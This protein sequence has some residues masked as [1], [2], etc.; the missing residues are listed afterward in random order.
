MPMHCAGVWRRGRRE[1]CRPACWQ[2]CLLETAGEE[3]FRHLTRAEEKAL[4]QPILRLR[5]A[6]CHPQALISYFC[7]FLYS[8]V[9]VLYL[10]WLPAVLTI[11]SRSP[12]SAV[13]QVGSGG[14]KSL[15]TAKAPMTM[16]A[17][18]GG[19]HQ[20]CFARVELVWLLTKVYH[21]KHAV[22]LPTPN[23]GGCTGRLLKVYTFRC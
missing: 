13:E 8:N 5:Q 10:A 4:L 22:Q 17:H 23:Q 20:S 2:Q 16:D 19:E 6:C 18:L 1:C 12:H 3:C 15:A 14:I 21:L 7:T 11:L 9:A